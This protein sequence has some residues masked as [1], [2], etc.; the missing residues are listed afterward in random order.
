MEALFSSD[1]EAEANQKFT[2]STSLL[3]CYFLPILLMCL[4]YENSNKTLKIN[5]KNKNPWSF[6]GL[7]RKD[8]VDPSEWHSC[9]ER[10]QEEDQDWKVLGKENGAEVP[11]LLS[12]GCNF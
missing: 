11:C 5:K 12:V 3:S 4:F 9:S 2:P 6:S 7:T 1:E 8:I 10:V